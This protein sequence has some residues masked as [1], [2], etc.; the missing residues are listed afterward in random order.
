MGLTG[1]KKRP[2]NRKITHLRDTKLIIIATEG[3][4]TEKQYFKIF[5]NHRVQ[6][7]II[8]S[9]DNRSAPEYILERLNT[10]SEGYQIGD[11]DELWLMVDTD[12][13]PMFTKS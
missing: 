11:D 2:L 6:V 4:K 3:H 7:V 5:K 12:L 9:K 8:P 1:R 10:Y 13:E